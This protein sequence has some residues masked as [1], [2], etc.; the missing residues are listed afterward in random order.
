MSCIWVAVVLGIKIWTEINVLTF[1]LTRLGCQL[2]NET[3]RFTNL[4]Y[5]LLDIIDLNQKKSC[6]AP[7]PPPRITLR[8]LD[9]LLNHYYEVSMYI[10]DI[11]LW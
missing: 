8:F 4:Y 1:N 2:L 11:T 9:N 7:P 10:T 3:H 6:L 5:V